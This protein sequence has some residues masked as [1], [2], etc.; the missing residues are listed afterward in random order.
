MILRNRIKVSDNQIC[1]EGSKLPLLMASMDILE[2]HWFQEENEHKIHESA[3]GMRTVQASPCFVWITFTNGKVAH[4][5]HGK[6]VKPGGQEQWDSPVYNTAIE[7]M[8][9]QHVWLPAQDW[10]LPLMSCHGLRTGSVAGREEAIFFSGV[11]TGKLSMLQ[12][13]AHSH[14]HGPN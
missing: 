5:G 9:T 7:I 10:I 12:W 2:A 14:T 4:H 3:V 1:I 11:T 6:I 8:N 13:M